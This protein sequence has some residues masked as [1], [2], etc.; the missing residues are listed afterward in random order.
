V[1]GS[2]A[3]AT[4]RF[5]DWADENGLTDYAVSVRRDRVYVSLVRDRLADAEALRLMMPWE[6][7]GDDTEPGLPMF[8][9]HD[10][11]AGLNGWT[12]FGMVSIISRE[13]VPGHSERDGND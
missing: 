2:G 7:I 3:D 13:Q 9:N 11:I 12:V 6:Y 8:Q 1:T 5:L 4:R 10:E